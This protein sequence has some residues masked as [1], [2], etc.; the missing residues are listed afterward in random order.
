MRSAKDRW[1]VV[2]SAWS[3]TSVHGVYFSETRA[4]QVAS[5][6][7]KMIKDEAWGGGVAAVLPVLPATLGTVRL[8]HGGQE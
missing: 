5:R 8:M 1:V 3:E 6:I 4:E 2:V 7:N